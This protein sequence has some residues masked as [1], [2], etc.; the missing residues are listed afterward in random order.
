M[1]LIN[2]RNCGG[3]HYGSSVC[4]LLPEEL[5][6]EPQPWPKPDPFIDYDPI[7]KG[8]QIERAMIVDYIRA[9]REGG[10]MSDA[11]QVFDV[12]A[13]HIEE[14]KHVPPL[15]PSVDPSPADRKEKP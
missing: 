4:P 5:A 12:L 1:T 14:G 11:V 6:R 2:C 15:P 10:A 13:S 7:V 3:D 8:A 9:Q